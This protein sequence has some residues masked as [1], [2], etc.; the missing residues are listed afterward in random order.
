M[1]IYLFEEEYHF[2]I[3]NNSFENDQLLNEAD[4]DDIWF[5]LDNMPSPHGILFLRNIE[6]DK[7]PKRILM[8]CSEKIKE[9]SKSKNFRKI[10]VIYTL[11]K[12]IKKTSTPGKVILKKKTNKIVI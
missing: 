5:H 7:I 3:G 6:S 11:R 9:N 8:L 1:K 12:N 2:K 10:S 4:Q